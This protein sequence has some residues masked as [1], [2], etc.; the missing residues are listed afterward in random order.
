MQ[1][2]YGEGSPRS[3]WMT[4]QEAAVYLKIAL[5]TLRNW[6]SAHFIPFVKRGRVVRYHREQIDQWLAKGGCKGRSLPPLFA[7]ARDV[8]GK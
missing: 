3:P 1:Q 4:P 7:T 6:T 5:G 2:N 8:T